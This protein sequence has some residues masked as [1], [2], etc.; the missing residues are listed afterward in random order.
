MPLPDAEALLAALIDQ[1]RP[2]VTPE[3]AL[4]GIHTGGV[5][6]AERL[7][8]SLGLHA[9]PRHARRC[10]S[11]ATTTSASGCSPRSS[12][13]TFRSRSTAGDIVLVDDV[14]Y[15]GRTIR[16]AMNELFD[17]GR[18]ASVRLAALVDRGGR[19][20]PICRPVRR[21][22][23][24]IGPDEHI[25][26]ARRTKPTGSRSPSSVSRAGVAIAA[27]S[28][29]PSST[30][31]ASCSTCS[32]SKACRATILLPDPRHRALLRLGDRA[33]GEEGAAAAR[34][35]DLQP[36]LRALHAHPHHLRDRGQAPVRRR[37]Q[38]QH[39]HVRR[40]PR[41]RPLLDT[42]ANLSAMHADM[43]IV[44]HAESGAPISSRA[45]SR[46]TSTSSTPATGAMR[47][48]RRRC[49]TCSPSATTRAT[50]RRLKV[51]I[52]GDI[53]HSRVAR[54]RDPRAHHARR[55]GGARDRAAH[56]A[57]G[58]GR[59]SSA[60]TCTTTWRRA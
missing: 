21:R 12:L 49:S 36:V 7:H 16:A 48:R 47:T 14:L 33:R 50:S 57:A 15:T 4:V 28:A 26:A 54:S 58:A 38:S 52:V 24:E 37:G 1:M 19:E 2:V 56:A 11:T 30:P 8:A 25:D 32:R 51:A 3:T 9:A 29:I 6:L 53:L 35:G 55:A 23:A 45:T 40:R 31:A 18:P 59:A 10:P 39:R 34:Q 27:C 13:R 5:W 44:R 20:L 60:C 43:F 22:R 42:V 17:Y 46:P 41:A